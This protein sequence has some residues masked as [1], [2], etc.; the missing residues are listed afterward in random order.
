MVLPVILGSAVSDLGLADDQ[1]G[2][3]GSS[4]LSGAALSALVAA[5]LVRSLN[6][7]M[8]AYTALALEC[9]GF[10]VA[11]EVDQFPHILMPLFLASVGGG[12]AVSLALTVLSDH[13]RPERMFGFALTS[14]V[15]FQVLGLLTLS[16]FVEP[17]RFD[18]CLYT[19][20]GIAFIGLCLVLF[21]PVRGTMPMG[22]GGVSLSSIVGQPLALLSLAGCLLFFINI[23]AV[24]AYVE[25]MGSL[26]GIAPNALGQVLAGSVACGMLG[27]LAAAWQDRRFGYVLPLTVATAGT[28]F[29]L[30]LMQVPMSLVAL[31]TAFAVY[32]F[33]WNYSLT[34][35]YAV[36]T[37]VDKSGRFVAAAPAFH[38]IG[39]AI[40]PVV[41]AM[42]LTSTSLLPVNYIAA[43]AVV[44]S[45]AAFYL[46]LSLADSRELRAG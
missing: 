21:L 8:L 31:S 35:Q 5:M 43:A 7:R 4:L 19:L 18:L 23:G 38:A 9:V 6:W 40:G 11:S 37:N 44:L 32:N 41:A 26:S 13:T 16:W 30:Y 39:G 34:Y 10:L 29:A 3:V 28:L 25:R 46:A 15:A 36:V 12:I 27:S 17:G 45:L 42:L 22:T 33:V 1:I 24:W 14:Q 2:L 20:A